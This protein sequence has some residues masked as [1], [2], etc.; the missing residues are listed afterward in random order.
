LP[1]EERDRS[2]SAPRS[3]PRSRTMASCPSS[4]VRAGP[5]SAVR[6][7]ARTSS[8][9]VSACG[10]RGFRR[11][12]VVWSPAPDRPRLLDRLGAGHAG[13]RHALCRRHAPAS[14]P[15][16]SGA[17]PAAARSSS[18]LGGFV[19]QRADPRRPLFVAESQHVPSAR[20]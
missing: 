16:G 1:P 7:I 10:S 20:S 13:D 12:A 14:A 4:R 17:R 5:A 6:A 9:P 8:R 3:C 19:F 2:A 11:R 15:H 18:A